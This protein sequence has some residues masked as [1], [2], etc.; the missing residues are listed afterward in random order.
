MGVD[1]YATSHRAAF[2]DQTYY[3][4]SDDCK[5]EFES[6]PDHYARRAH[7]TLVAGK[8]AL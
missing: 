4:C 5:Q 3:F 1:R 7:G 8:A 6:K 2:A